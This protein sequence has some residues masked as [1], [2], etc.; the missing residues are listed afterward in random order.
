LVGLARFPAHGQEEADVLG[1]QQDGPLEG[2]GR[3]DFHLAVVD[4]GA[5]SEGHAAVGVGHGPAP[6]ERMRIRTR[7]QRILYFAQAHEGELLAANASV[8]HDDRLA[9]GRDSAL[10]VIHGSAAQPRAIHELLLHSPHVPADKLVADTEQ[11]RSRTTAA[12]ERHGHPAAFRGGCGLL[13][14]EGV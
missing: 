14:H 5:E 1:Q 2:V 8:P 3:E 13:P 11:E 4:A 12:H 7:R 6:V 9:I 10:E